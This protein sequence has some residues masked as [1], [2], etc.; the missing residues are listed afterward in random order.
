MHPNGKVYLA[1]SGLGDPEILT[2]LPKS[3]EL[4]D[5]GKYA[6]DHLLC[7]IGEKVN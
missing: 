2:S 3:A 7:R 4:S 5:V 6:G 1:G